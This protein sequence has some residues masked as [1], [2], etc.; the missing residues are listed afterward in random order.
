MGDDEGQL[1]FWQVQPRVLLRSL[2]VDEEPDGV[3]NDF[4]FSRSGDLVAIALNDSTAI[5]KWR[6]EKKVQD[7]PYRTKRVDFSRVSDV[8]ARSGVGGAQAFSITDGWEGDELGLVKQS[9]T[10]FLNDIR[11]SPDAKYV[12]TCSWDSVIRLWD[13]E[14]VTSEKVQRYGSPLSV[15]RGHTGPAT[16]L[17]FSPDGNWIASTSHDGTIRLWPGRPPLD[18]LERTVST[19]RGHQRQTHDVA[20]S[21]DGLELV[22]A[23]LDG[24]IRI[25][26]GA[27]THSPNT[28]LGHQDFVFGIGFSPDS[29][30]IASGSFDGEVRMWDS[31][32]QELLFNEF[33]HDHQVFNT[34]FSPDGKWLAS[35][36]CVWRTDDREGITF[37]TPG[38][39]VITSVNSRKSHVVELP[40]PAGV[41]ALAFLPNGQLIMGDF[42][43]KLWLWDIERNAVVS[44]RTVG[45]AG[46]GRIDGLCCSSNG[47]L[48]AVALWRNRVPDGDRRLITFRTNDVLSQVSEISKNESRRL[49][50]AWRIAFVPDSIGENLVATGVR[51]FD[52]MSGTKSHEWAG[53]GSGSI[54]FSPDGQTMAKSGMDQTIHLWNVA[55][56][57]EVAT[58]P[59]HQGMVMCLAFSPDGTMLAS[60]SEDNTIR[61]WRTDL[62]TQ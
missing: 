31:Q 13:V 11:L 45:V 16:R 54:A 48:I 37:D 35:C 15:M 26:P 47:D 7:L 22:S 17:D 27:P 51:F 32:T 57:R 24:T 18:S 52:V 33:L 49:G 34:V 30:L 46:E 3:V 25:W 39:V 1:T 56:E 14:Q 28:L 44:S 23:S 2:T 5:W 9:H 58:I 38:K 61:I 10:S 36:S 6:E 4:S 62:S 60:A 53:Q 8:L 59:A 41:R 50:V 40:E 55:T 20:F 43:G 21:H 19:L 12:A 29:Q 42:L